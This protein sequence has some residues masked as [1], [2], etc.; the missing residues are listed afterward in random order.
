MEEYNF[1][2]MS[3]IPILNG[4]VGAIL[5]TIIFWIFK[6]FVYKKIG[7]QKL[8]KNEIKKYMTDDVYINY[9]N[10]N[11]PLKGKILGKDKKGNLIFHHHNI[12]FGG[13]PIFGSLLKINENQIIE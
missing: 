10:H 12:M 4:I 13:N 5:I 8:Q 3:V 2:M 1:I 7:I 11:I 9:K 6:E